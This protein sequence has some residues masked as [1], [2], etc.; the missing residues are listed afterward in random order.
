M[1][2][3]QIPT[4]S[5]PGPRVPLIDGSQALT[6]LVE[7]SSPMS[8]A[9]DSGQEVQHHTGTGALE[10]ACGSHQRDLLFLRERP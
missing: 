2:G 10:V 5:G 9:S 1:L 3:G 4:R 8:C 6:Q 7:M